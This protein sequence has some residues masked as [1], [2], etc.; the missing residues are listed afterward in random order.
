MMLL[1][2]MGQCLDVLAHLLGRVGGRSCHE[3][4]LISQ[5]RHLSRDRFCGVMVRIV[6]GESTKCILLEWKGGGISLVACSGGCRIEPMLECFLDHSAEFDPRLRGFAQLVPILERTDIQTRGVEEADCVS[7]QL[8]V[9]IGI[10]PDLSKFREY[11]RT[12][13][14]A[15]IALGLP[16]R[17]GKRLF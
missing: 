9:G 17:L 2:L 5:S 14:S 4:A 15:T 12:V 11:F 1:L 7:D 16:L 6:G 3:L 8:F 10:L 13:E